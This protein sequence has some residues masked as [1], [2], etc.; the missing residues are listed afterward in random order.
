MGIYIEL[1]MDNYTES[2]LSH[3]QQKSPQ[4]FELSFVDSSQHPSI[5]VQLTDFGASWISCKLAK[6]IV[7]HNL[8][9]NEKPA[10]QEVLSTCQDATL[11]PHHPIIRSVYLG[12][13]V[14]RWANRI[15]NA[16]ITGPDGILQL[17][18]PTHQ[19]HLL[20]GGEVGFDQHYWQ[21]KDQSPTSICFELLSP[22]L[23]QGFPGN[24]RVQTRY[25]LIGPM[26]LKISYQAICDQDTPLSLTNH[27]YF[28]L[29]DASL[30]KPEQ[31]LT[32]AFQ[33]QLKINSDWVCPVNDEL[34]PA[35]Q[36]DLSCVHDT[37]LDFR[38]FKNL[39]PPGLDHG[40]LFNPSTNESDHQ[41]ALRLNP[42][43]SH[44]RLEMKISTSLPAVQV[45]T[46]EALAGVPKAD[47]TGA[48]LHA[49]EGIAIEPGFLPDS[50]NQAHWPQPSCILKAG[51]V[52][53]HWIVY[54]WANNL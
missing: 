10:Y 30:G 33:H 39:T 34:I 19:K 27:A 50:P 31:D 29:L 51:Q 42:V 6:N 26:S 11:Y 2:T 20:H 40:F 24:L 23:D 21:V 13:T 44:N 45:Y 49:F 7:S 3:N 53:H 25:E 41:V 37:D 8:S 22:H 16:Q 48:S 35:K 38:E 54:E 43:H 15:A 14:G 9:P 18:K 1:F 12:A 4:V 47:G 46:G 28:N 52:W 36:Q 32:A 17:K 5:K